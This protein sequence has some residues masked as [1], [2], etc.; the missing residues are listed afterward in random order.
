MCV[1]FTPFFVVF[2]SVFVLVYIFQTMASL[3]TNNYHGLHEYSTF[4]AST[5]APH[6]HPN[7]G[8][9]EHEHEHNSTNQCVKCCCFVCR[10]SSALIFHP[11]GPFRCC[12]DLFIM[13]LLIY[14]SI[15]IPY[16]ISFGQAQSILFVGLFVDAF[17]LI[18]IFLNFH[19][20]YFD[21][22]DNLRLVTNKKYICKKYFRTWFVIDFVTC[23]PFDFIFE[24]YSIDPRNGKA[25]VYIKLLR[26]FR[27]LR[28]IKILRFVKMLRIFDAFMKQFI[29]REVIVF[30][31]LF[32]IIFGM[33]M[34]AHF[35]GLKYEI[36]KSICVPNLL[37]M[38]YLFKRACGGLWV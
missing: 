1:A 26:I 16:T 20:A 8:H 21:K 18:D 35:S 34:F 7:T 4:S 17:L 12:W 9:H 37:F 2:Y 22:Y 24:F 25:L 31:K 19:T 5:I 30:M 32:K 29:V 27:L 3:E 15:E 33:L 36:C 6:R 23:I 28:I 13:L 14:T 10:L 11:V 38:I